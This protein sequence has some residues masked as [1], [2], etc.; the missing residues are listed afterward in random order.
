MALAMRNPMGILPFITE[1]AVQDGDIVVVGSAVG[2]C[3]FAGGASPTTSLLGVVMRPDGSTA[4]VGDQVDV[5]TAGIY[6]VRSGGSITAN[7]LLTSG[8]TTGTAIAEAAGAGVNVGVIGK[9]L[10]DGSS[11]DR[12]PTLITPFIKQG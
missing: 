1:S 2:K 9:A 7:N 3:A 6:P 8:G 11:G 4:T 5:V 10:V 12:V